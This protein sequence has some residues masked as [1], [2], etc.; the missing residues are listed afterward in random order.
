MNILRFAFI[1]NPAPFRATCKGSQC[2]R[3]SQHQDKAVNL[4]KFCGFSR[5]VGLERALVALRPTS[6][7]FSGDL[8]AETGRS[9][10][11]R[12]AKFIPGLSTSSHLA[13]CSCQ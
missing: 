13:S 11:P 6:W 1:S 8:L 2:P 5:D 3:K 7:S 10:A 9:P 4:E 12:R